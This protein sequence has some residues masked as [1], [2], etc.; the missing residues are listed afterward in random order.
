MKEATHSK[1]L[2]DS[3]LQKYFFVLRVSQTYYT[4]ELKSSC[5]AFEFQVKYM[6]K[7]GFGF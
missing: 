2:K 3:V 6:G 7:E 4:T 1:E 5:L